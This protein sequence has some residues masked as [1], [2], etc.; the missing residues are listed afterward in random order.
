[1]MEGGSQM[2]WGNHLGYLLIQ[3]PMKHQEDP[4][5]HVLAAKK[6]GDRK[7]ASLEGIFAYWSGALIMKIAGPIVRTTTQVMQCFKYLKRMSY[8]TK[9]SHLWSIMCE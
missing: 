9:Q 4:L 3:I 1:M 5:D 2:R 7:K 8:F 6:I